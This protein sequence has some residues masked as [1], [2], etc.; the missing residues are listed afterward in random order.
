MTVPTFSFSLRDAAN[1]DTARR[2]VDLCISTGRF[3]RN[4]RGQTC[5]SPADDDWLPLTRAAELYWIIEDGQTLIVE[6]D[7]G[8]DATFCLWTFLNDQ[9]WKLPRIGG[10]WNPPKPLPVRNVGKVRR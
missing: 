4:E 10:K 8:D 9:R 5:W 3:A 7:K 2:F 6:G 1:R